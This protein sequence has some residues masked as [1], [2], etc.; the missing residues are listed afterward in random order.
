MS[1][2]E[3]ASLYEDAHAAGELAANVCVPTPM[4]VKYNGTTECFEDGA[5]GLLVSLSGQQEVSLCPI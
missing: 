4:Y 3:N 2:Y 5:C 1:D